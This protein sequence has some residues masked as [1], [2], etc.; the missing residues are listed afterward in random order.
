MQ[1]EPLEPKDD[2]LISCRKALLRLSEVPT[3]PVYLRRYAQL[4]ASDA[5]SVMDKFVRSIALAEDDEP[6][7]L[8]E[9][10]PI[11]VAEVPALEL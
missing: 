7:L 5:L 9:P 1:A 10:E 2:A 4:A 8:P 11:V 6:D 3:V